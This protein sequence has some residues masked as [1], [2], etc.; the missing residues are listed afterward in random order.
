[1]GASYRFAQVAEFTVGVAGGKVKRLSEGVNRANSGTVDPQVAR[2]DS[3][4]TSL[5]G[6]LTFRIGS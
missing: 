1:M 5:F 4:H 2:I 3:F 6:A